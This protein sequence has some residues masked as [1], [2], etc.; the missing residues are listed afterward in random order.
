MVEHYLKSVGLISGGVF[1]KHLTDY[2]YK[3]SF[4]Q[5]INGSQYQ[6]AQ[7]LNGDAA[8][9]RGVEVAV[10]D[11]L[12]FL[13]RP[14]DGIGLYANYTFTDSTAHFPSHKGDATLPGQSRHVGNVAASYEKGGFT[15]RASLNF[16]GAYLDTVG[17][18]ST[19]DRFY[20]TNSQLD[21]TLLQRVAHGMHVYV[22]FLNLNDSLLRYY[23]SV[24]DRTPAPACSSSSA[25]T[26][27]CRTCRA[28]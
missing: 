7:P 23:Q 25:T 6:V 11:R 16:H 3:Y 24:P 4:A 20:D 15:G 9:L 28:C 18:D 1:F 27:I 26:P 13:P 22:N 19:Q 12:S 21:V 17:S 14:F 2:I 10:Q 5:P 8:T